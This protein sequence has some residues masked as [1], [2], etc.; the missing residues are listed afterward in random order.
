MGQRVEN[1]AALRGTNR[2][3]TNHDNDIHHRS[4]QGPRLRDGTS[5]GRR[6]PHRVPRS[7]ETPRSGPR[8]RRDDLGARFVEIDVTDDFAAAAAP[9]DVAALGGLAVLIVNAGVEVGPR[10]A[11]SS[12]PRIR[13]PTRCR[14]SSTPMSSSR[15]G[16]STHFAQLEQ[17]HS[18]V[19]VNV[20]SGLAL[21]RC[22][23]TRRRRHTST[24]RSQIRRRR[25]R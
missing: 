19:I 11:T 25:P 24:L 17:S 6:R 10:M 22:L 14:M 12:C 9:K 5:A 8:G 21:T 4:E 13:P 16:F 15:S 3:E 7:R 2:K 23:S 1:T 20:R 18:P